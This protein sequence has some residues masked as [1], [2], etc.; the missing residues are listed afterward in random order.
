MACF[1]SL[2]TYAGPSKGHFSHSPAYSGPSSAFWLL[3]VHLGSPVAHPSLL[4]AHFGALE[5]LL[6]IVAPPV[7]F[8]GPIL[9]LLGLILVSRDPS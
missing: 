2:E 8:L 6:S 5:A 3:W 7:A 9:A 4:G 1:D